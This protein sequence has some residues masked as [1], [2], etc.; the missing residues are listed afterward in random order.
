MAVQAAPRRTGR[1]PKQA[2]GVPTRERVLRAA[3]DV[4]AERGFGQTKITEIAERAAISGPAVYK[5]FD[6]KADVLMQAAR[7]SLE[8]TLDPAK[9]GAP[10][11]R[12]TAKRWLSPAFAQTRHLI[13]E[14]HLTASRERDVAALLAE[15]HV[16][17]AEAW[18]AAAPV[19][20]ERI[21]AFYLLLLG[22]AQVDAL[23][24]LHTDPAGVQQHVDRMVDA[25][26]APTN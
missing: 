11:P 8:T 7:Y 9:I 18:Q 3:V 24:S 16:E 12:E 15:W 26:F 25:L 10:N 14:L 21:T 17:R 5:H 6:D 22:L 1:P 4:F 13:L 23:S 2:G 19:D 20:R